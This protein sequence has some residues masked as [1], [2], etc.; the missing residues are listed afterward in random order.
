LEGFAP[1]RGQFPAGPPKTLTRKAQFLWHF[2]IKIENLEV[3][4]RI[5]CSNIR[6]CGIFVK[7]FGID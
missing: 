4:K 5:L 1:F 3:K 2:F 7:E 6:D